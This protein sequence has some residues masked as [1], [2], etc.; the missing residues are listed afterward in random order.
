MRPESAK[1]KTRSRPPSGKKVRPH[2]A[3]DACGTQATQPVAPP[4]RG[5]G[6][7]ILM[8]VFCFVEH[9]GCLLNN[10]EENNLIA[11]IGVVDRRFF[12]C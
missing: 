11:V 4:T 8:H 3:K 9:R 1:V 6:G 10:T 12:I 2:S 5:F 7:K